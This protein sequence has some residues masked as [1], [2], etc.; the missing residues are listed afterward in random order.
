MREFVITELEAKQRFDK[1]LLKL[2]K[3]AGKGYIYKMLRKRSI[4]L[5]GKKAEGSAMLNQGDIVRLFMKD[6]TIEEFMG[7]NPIDAPEVSRYKN[8]YDRLKKLIEV[9]Y[10]DKNVLIVN[11]PAGVLAQKAE[12]RDISCNEWLIG[13]LLDNKCILPE[14]LRTFKPSVC[15]RLDKNTSGLLICGKTLLGTQ[16]MSELIRERRIKKFY[17][18]FVKGNFKEK[19]HI[20]GYLTRNRTNN[21]VFISEIELPDSEAIETKFCPIKATDK[22]SYVEVE[23]ITGKHHQIRAHVASIG[24]PILGDLK[25][26]DPDFNKITRVKHQFLHSYRL[27]FP[28]MEGEFKELSKAKIVAKEPVYFLRHKEHIGYN[29]NLEL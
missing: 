9:V 15:N 6:E 3:K 21:K 28:K 12:P 10:E 27:E 14:Q 20:N 17:R 26:G 19:M 11:K 5:N 22:Y 24:H 18:T 4:T 1:Y 8:A 13:Y 2:L 29:G 16:Q 7:N 25:Y 23:L